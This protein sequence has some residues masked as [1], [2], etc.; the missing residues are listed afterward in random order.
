[1]KK[2]ISVHTTELTHTQ[3][4]TLSKI[5]SVKQNKSIGV[6]TLINTAIVE[7]LN[8]RKLEAEVNH[9]FQKLINGAEN[10]IKN[11]QKRP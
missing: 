7:Y 8:N 10:Q 9:E 2:N 11:A 3:L 1:M 6:S 4:L 5:D